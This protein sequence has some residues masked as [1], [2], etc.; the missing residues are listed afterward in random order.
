[1]RL[2]IAIE[3]DEEILAELKKIQTYWQSLGMKGNFT[4]LENLHLTLAFIG[5]YKDADYVLDAL[6][7]VTFEPF[8]IELDGIGN[9]DDLYFA[10]I[11]KNEALTNVVRRIRRTLAEKNIPYDRKRFSPHI[12]LVRKAEFNGKA[13]KL[14]KQTPKSEMKV[15]SI[16][17]FSSTRGKNGMIYTRIG[18]TII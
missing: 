16:S 15:S 5:E 9:F 10:G 7:K 3:F 11:S 13:E 1:M 14:A 4:P 17:L 18:V 6:E 12:T 2:F 8:N